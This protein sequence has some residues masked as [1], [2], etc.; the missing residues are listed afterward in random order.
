MIDHTADVGIRA[1]GRTKEEVFANCALGMVSLIMDIESIERKKRVDISVGAA[2]AGGLLIGW[3]S[4]IIFLIE[5]EGWALGEFGVEEI[6]DTMVRG[7]GAG[8]PL[9]PE[10]HRVSGEIKA[11]TYHMLELKEENGAWTAQVIFDV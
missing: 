11:P 2:G 9:D 4:E 6:T 5:V 1:Y 7:W 3:L 10:R 8:E